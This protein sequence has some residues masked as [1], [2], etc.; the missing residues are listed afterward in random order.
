MGAMIDFTVDYDTET[1]A[2]SN[3]RVISLG[4]FMKI[5]DN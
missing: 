3:Y 1:C 2:D 4:L 5:S